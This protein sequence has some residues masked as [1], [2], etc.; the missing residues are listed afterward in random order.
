MNNKLRDYI[1]QSNLSME[2]KDLWD[3]IID[4]LTEDMA[5]LFYEEIGEDEAELQDLTEEI[6]K[7]YE[8]IENGD[9]DQVLASLEK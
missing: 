4:G 7:Q 8:H 2:D 1:A 9:I 3:D 6:R 5:D